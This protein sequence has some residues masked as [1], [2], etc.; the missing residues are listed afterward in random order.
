MSGK[1]LAIFRLP[2]PQAAQIGHVRVVTDRNGQHYV[3][4]SKVVQT[5]V[6]GIHTALTLADGRSI[7]VLTKAFRSL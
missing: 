7:F 6:T 2:I 5:A 3:D 1:Q 4:G